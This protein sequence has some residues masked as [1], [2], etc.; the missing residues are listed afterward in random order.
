MKDRDLPERRPPHAFS[1]ENPRLR[2]QSKGAGALDM[3]PERSNLLSNR[4]VTGFDE[5]EYPP[6]RRPASGGTGE[7][8]HE[9][10]W[11]MDLRAAG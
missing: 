10:R 2:P 8:P 3:D 1:G 9:R 6:K 7:N 4:I 11:G 5:D